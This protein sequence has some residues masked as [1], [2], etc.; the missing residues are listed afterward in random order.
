LSE[1]QLNTLSLV[2]KNNGIVDYSDERMNVSIIKV[3][4]PIF[5]GDMHSVKSYTYRDEPP[6]KLPITVFLG[7]QDT[8]VS[9]EDHLGW[10]DHSLVTCEFQQF[11]S[12]HLFIREKEIRLKVIQK[13]TEKL[14]HFAQVEC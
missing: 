9:P 3:L 11:N 12:G 6:L 8:W 1:E 13:I 4:L 7:R 5:I 2:F 10:T 14:L